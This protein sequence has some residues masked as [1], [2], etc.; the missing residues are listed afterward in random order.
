[1]T[2]AFTAQVALRAVVN[3]VIHNS[4][5]GRT[6]VQTVK[7]FFTLLHYFRL[8]LEADLPIL[9]ELSVAWVA[10]EENYQKEKLVATPDTT[11][12]VEGVFASNVT[13]RVGSSKHLILPLSARVG[14]S[15]QP[16]EPTR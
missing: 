5:A 10:Q 3:R 8:L 6:L 1:M 4:L 14:L 9:S 16:I 12:D 15:E 2:E 11:V 13:S 7:I